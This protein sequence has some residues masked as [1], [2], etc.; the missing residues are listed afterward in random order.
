MGKLPMRA[1]LATTLGGA[2]GTVSRLAGRGDG[3]V[4]LTRKPGRAEWEQ[5]AA[6]CAELWPHDE[7]AAIVAEPWRPDRPERK[8]NRDPGS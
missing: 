7:Y 1:R 5:L 4:M 2:A 8:V 6:W 3:S